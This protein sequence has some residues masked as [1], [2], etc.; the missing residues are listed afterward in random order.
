MMVLLQQSY[1]WG[2]VIVRDPTKH[3]SANPALL[4]PQKKF[5]FVNTCIGKE[6]FQVLHKALLQ[7]AWY[8]LWTWTKKRPSMP[9]NSLVYLGVLGHFFS[10]VIQL[11]GSPSR[12]ISSSIDIRI[13]IAKNISWLNKRRLVAQFKMKHGWLGFQLFKRR[14]NASVSMWLLY[15]VY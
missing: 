6:D 12:D 1:L 13:W 11:F 5:F 4:L 7:R 14:E 9:S 2:C 3:S 10:Q 8:L 15:I